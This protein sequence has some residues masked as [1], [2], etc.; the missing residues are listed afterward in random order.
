M[1]RESQEPEVAPAADLV[2]DVEEGRRVLRA[3]RRVDDEDLAT[4]LDHVEARAVRRERE[5]GDLVQPLAMSCWTKPGAGLGPSSKGAAGP[6][7][8]TT[9]ATAT[10]STGRP[11]GLGPSTA[12]SASGTLSGARIHARPGLSHLRDPRRDI[13]MDSTSPATEVVAWLGGWLAPGRTVPRR[14]TGGTASCPHGGAR[15]SSLPALPPH[16]GRSEGTSHTRCGER[17]ER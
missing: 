13:L 9:R 17:P 15:A 3:R 8:R 16:A 11:S 6:R 4:A 12:I 2:A 10:R 5:A 1:Q 7:Q 14:N